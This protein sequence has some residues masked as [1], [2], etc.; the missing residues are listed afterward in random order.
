[1]PGPAYSHTTVR[2]VLTG[3]TVS[4]SANTVMGR[5]DILAYVS[6]VHYSS[7]TAVTYQ[8]RNNAFPILGALRRDFWTHP[9]I[10][11]HPGQLDC[12]LTNAGGV[13]VTPWCAFT[14]EGEPVSQ[15]IQ[16]GD[17]LAVKIH[18][19]MNNQLAINDLWFRCSGLLGASCSDVLACG[20]FD[21]LWA[22]TVKAYLPTAATY[23]GTTLAIRKPVPYPTV[24]S[25]AGQG[26]GSYNQNP[27]PSQSC[28][29]LSMY[30]NVVGPA[31]RG[32]LYMPFPNVAFNGTDG[33]PNS[34][35]KSAWAAL[36]SLI[37]NPI[38]LGAG[39]NT[40]NAT[41]GVFHRLTGL[42]SDIQTAVAEGKWGTQK[43]RGSYGRMNPQPF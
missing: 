41:W 25:T 8:W 18:C 15:T 9:P 36:A 34:T 3:A 29:V 40:I 17:V 22:A 35:G 32:R 42:T 2:E 24:R 1:M 21:A 7:P 33:K 37:I 31:G 13:T 28:G 39:G 12:V 4:F 11:S 6:T 30:T 10:S 16:N 14:S 5:R 38:L 43:R 27:L 26:V 23:L 20:D 19:Y